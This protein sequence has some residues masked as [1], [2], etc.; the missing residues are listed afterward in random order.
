M[1][2][3]STTRM[4]D[5]A[6]SAEWTKDTSQPSSSAVPPGGEDGLAADPAGAV[7]EVQAGPGLPVVAEEPVELQGGEGAMRGMK[8]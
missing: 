7:V 3:A 5:S 8:L 1:V 2:W 4:R 6:P